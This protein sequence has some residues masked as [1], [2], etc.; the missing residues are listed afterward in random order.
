MARVPRWD[1]TPYTP[2]MTHQSM[3]NRKR[4]WHTLISI[5]LLASPL[6]IQPINLELVHN[7]E[8]PTFD[9]RLVCISYVIGHKSELLSS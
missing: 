4:N 7:N 2:H 8:R 9:L 3:Q 1:E 5:V 6:K